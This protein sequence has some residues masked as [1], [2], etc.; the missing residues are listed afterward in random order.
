MILICSSPRRTSLPSKFPT[1]PGDQLFE[2]IKT[3]RANDPE[4]WAWVNDT[5]IFETEKKAVEV[6]IDPKNLMADVNR[7]NNQVTPTK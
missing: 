2:E 6:K 5:Y 3:W 4:S 1:A 7:E